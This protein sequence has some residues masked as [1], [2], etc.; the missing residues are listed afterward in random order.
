MGQEGKQD[1]KESRTGRKVG[2]EG[3]QD[4]KLRVRGY[5]PP[6]TKSVQH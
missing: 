5:K 3:K 1:R 6:I 4:W 2:Q